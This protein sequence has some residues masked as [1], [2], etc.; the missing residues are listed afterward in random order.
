MKAL[1]EFAAGEGVSVVVEIDDEDPG[2]VRAGAGEVVAKAQTTLNQALEVLRPMAKAVIEK[3]DNLEVRKPS[4]IEVEMGIKL[5][6]KTGAVLA[7]A[8]GECHVKLKLEW[9]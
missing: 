4:G 2:Y 3:I 8:G 6:A 1:V 9:K 7:S 5:N